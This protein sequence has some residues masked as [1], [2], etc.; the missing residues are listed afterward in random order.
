MNEER[1]KIQK[2]W[3]EK[4][5]DSDVQQTRAELKEI[6]IVCVET[7]DEIANATN[8]DGRQE[9]KCWDF[10]SVQHDEQK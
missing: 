2:R 4:R 3:N 8:Q 6:I 9:M 10:D 7:N 5:A 1:T